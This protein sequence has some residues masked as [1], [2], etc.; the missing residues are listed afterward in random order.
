MSQISGL[1]L[2]Q[3]YVIWIVC[4]LQVSLWYN[5]IK[6][7]L[8]SYWFTFFLVCFLQYIIVFDCKLLHRNKG[9]CQYSAELEVCQTKVEH[10]RIVIRFFLLLFTTLCFLPSVPCLP[11]FL[12]PLRLRAIDR[13]WYVA[14]YENWSTWIFWCFW[15]SGPNTIWRKTS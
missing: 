14:K 8:D 1:L 15:R 13:E 7:N 11:F 9:G 5:R 3:L 10:A 6:K 12:L 2:E 4:S